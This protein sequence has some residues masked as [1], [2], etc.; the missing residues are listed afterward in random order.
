[1]PEDLKI[2]PEGV[3]KFESF[4]TGKKPVEGKFSV[5][6]Q[7]LVD[8]YADQARDAYQNWQAQV[9]AQDKQWESE[10]KQRFTPAQLAA[11]ETGVG[12]LSSFEP[13]FRELSKG[14]RNHPAFV[15]AMRVIG[16]RLSEDTFE[17]A[18]TA[19]TAA[20]RAA[21]DVMYPKRN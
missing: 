14:Y 11:A 9:V 12:F 1:M 17:I 7:E 16:E 15:N 2:A 20:R 3:A 5:T 8:L 13:A 21:K 18:G 4:V 6:A 10:S 19:P